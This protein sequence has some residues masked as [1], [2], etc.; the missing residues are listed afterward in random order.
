MKYNQSWEIGEE[1]ALKYELEQEGGFECV[2]CDK[3]GHPG[4]GD[5]MGAAGRGLYETTGNR[6][7]P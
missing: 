2:T 3:E 4:R 1:V 7:S 6:A 5:Q